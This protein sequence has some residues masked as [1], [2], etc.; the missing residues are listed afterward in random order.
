MYIGLAKASGSG[1]EF[2]IVDVGGG[3][4]PASPTNPILKGNYPVGNGVNAIYV[5]DN[6]AYIASPNTENVT[7]LD[8]SNP[9]S[10]TRVGGYTPGT[11][12]KGKS[13]FVKDNVIYLGRTFG[14]NELY[15]LNGPDGTFI[16]SK[17]IGSD[18]STS[19]NSL[20]VREYL[21]FLVTNLQF[22]IWNTGGSISQYATPLTLPGTG[23]ALGCKGNYMYVGSVPANNKGSLS[24]VGPKSVYALKL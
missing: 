8:I 2:Y 24:I 4:V 23:T 11:K 22:Q 12:N 21:A 13:I 3:S 6:Y 18:D 15:M 9:L 10:P 5:K 14:T 1:S 19:I 17:D 20:L 7:V 16:K